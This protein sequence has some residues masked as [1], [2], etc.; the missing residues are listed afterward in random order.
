M[1]IYISKVSSAS[2]TITYSY[3]E[4]EHIWGYI[5]QG[6][7]KA[8]IS[9]IVG[10]DDDN[11]HEGQRAIELALGQQNL[12]AK[13]GLD[14]YR[15]GNI[16]SLSFGESYG[17]SKTDVSF[18]IVERVRVEDDGILS[19]LS[20]SI[21][22]P[23]DVE[24]FS[25][26]FSFNRTT[27]GYSYNRNV[28]LKYNQDAGD[29]FLNKALLFL[30]NIYLRRRPSY[31][32][33]IDGISEYGRTDSGFKPTTSETFDLINKQISFSESLQVSR[34]EN[35][36]SKATTFT[37]AL[38][39][40]GYT[41]KSYTVDLAALKEPYEKNIASGVSL[42]L[43]ELYDENT[44]QFGLPVSFEKGV[45]NEGGRAN[46]SIVFKNDPKNKNRTNITYTATRTTNV[47]DYDTY[48]FN[49]QVK[50]VGADPSQTFTQNKDFWTA[51][52]NYPYLK[53][54]I[55]FP[56]VTSGDLKE[57]SRNVSFN[58]FENLVS[59]N[60]TFTM[61][62]LYGYKFKRTIEISDQKQVNRNS[63]V[64][65]YGDSEMIV[66]NNGKTLG[67]YGISAS[68]ISDDINELE[69]GV[70][71][72]ASG[73]YPDADFVYLINQT[74]NLNLIEQSI[75]ANLEYSYFNE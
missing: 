61:N 56:E 63:I 64:P 49:L 58:P 14:E 30:K 51:N 54:P 73:Y 29:Q 12:A 70:L 68:M 7:Y 19:D 65:I 37:I 34:I 15:N 5:I 45:N 24:S 3:L 33:Q 9:D 69:T 42:V 50:S 25:E 32:F 18:T 2:T 31:G 35:D 46:L 16:T 11:L 59:D 36:F 52:T 74:T 41:T 55:L 72:F 4:S 48:S 60:S 67:Q 44:G 71:A 1:N 23:Q 6:N 47:A 20:Q 17:V 53:I 38:D 62:P 28:T 22:S 40:Q 8:D 21:P 75:S 66:Y 43:S 57:V 10:I 26:D 27:E 13:I 39:E